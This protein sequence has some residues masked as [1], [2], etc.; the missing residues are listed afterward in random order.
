M[1]ERFQERGITS[2]LPSPVL[3]NIEE[4]TQGKDA[5]NR[6]LIVKNILAA[7]IGP[8]VNMQPVEAPIEDADMCRE[9]EMATVRVER[10]ILVLVGHEVFSLSTLHPVNR[11]G[12]LGF[13][14]YSTDSSGAA[15]H[16]Q[17]GQGQNVRG[18]GS[19]PRPSHRPNQRR[20]T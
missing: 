14:V 8:V 1:L 18:P 7:W 20:S 4:G 9:I 6:Q 19:V 16:G 11:R 17:D 12:A 13:R 10:H 2:D 5:M 3:P 15:A